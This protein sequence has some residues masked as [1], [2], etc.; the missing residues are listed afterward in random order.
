MDIEFDDLRQFGLETWIILLQ[1]SN[2][3]TPTSSY[4]K[5]FKAQHNLKMRVLYDAS[6]VTGIYGIKETSI[7]SNEQGVIVNKFQSDA[8][9]TIKEALVKELATGPGQCKDELICNG[10]ACLPTPAADAMVCAEQC[11]PAAPNSCPTGKSCFTFTATHGAVL[12]GTAACFKVN[13]LPQ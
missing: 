5:T 10:H 13:L 3:A 2:F 7:V 4:C 12:A 6:G 11:D 8:P 1:D 9:A